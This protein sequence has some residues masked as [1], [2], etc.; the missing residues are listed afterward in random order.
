MLL[1][2]ESKHSNSIEENQK[3][4]QFVYTFIR[5]CSIIEEKLFDL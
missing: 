2:K 3:K 4:D 1:S 5:T